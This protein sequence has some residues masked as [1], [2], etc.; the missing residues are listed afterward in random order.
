VGEAGAD[1]VT[2]ALRWMV[3]VVVAKTST[4]RTSLITGAPL[5]RW[6]TPRRLAAPARADRWLRPRA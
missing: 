4:V 5:P 6:A 3:V 1:A 2:G